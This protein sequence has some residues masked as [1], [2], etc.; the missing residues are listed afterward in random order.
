M[1]APMRM[2]VCANGVMG[3]LPNRLTTRLGGNAG[4]RAP[5]LPRLGAQ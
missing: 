2:Q 1:W 5:G 4:P 3:R